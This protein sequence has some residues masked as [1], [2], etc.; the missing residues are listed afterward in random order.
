MEWKR[1]KRNT[2]SNINSDYYYYSKKARKEKWK[3]ENSEKWVLAVTIIQGDRKTEKSK[4][5]FFF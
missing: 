2:V 1:G 5:L 4:I 3:F